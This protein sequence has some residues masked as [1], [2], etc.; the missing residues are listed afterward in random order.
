MMQNSQDKDNISSL[1]GIP[2]NHRDA[3]NSSM[4]S[5]LKWQREPTAIATPSN[6]ARLN[7]DMI[8][9]PYGASRTRD[10]LHADRTSF[11]N[12][13][14]RSTVT[15][16]INLSSKKRKWD[17]TF[18]ENNNG[19]GKRKSQPKQL[20]ND[21]PPLA[22]DQEIILVQSDN[23]EDLGLPIT[24]DE[25]NIRP[26][27]PSSVKNDRARRNSPL[28]P[29]EMSD[30]QPPTSYSRTRGPTDGNNTRWL[31]E[32]L[33]RPTSPIEDYDDEFERD[34]GKVKGMVADYERRRQ[35]GVDEL[36][37]KRAAPPKIPF[38]DLK[39]GKEAPKA[40]PNTV[41]IK[42]RMKPKDSAKGIQLLPQ[43]QRDRSAASTSSKTPTTSQFTLPVKEWYLGHNHFREP[44]TL[45]F[46]KKDSQFTIGKHGHSEV[47]RLARDVDESTCSLDHA[48]VQIVTK[49]DH[50]GVSAIGPDH[51]PSFEP[52]HRTRGLILFSFDEGAA[53][54]ST[55]A[56]TH[57]CECLRGRNQSVATGIGFWKMHVLRQQ[58]PSRSRSVSVVAESDPE[59][60]KRDSESVNSTLKPR[61][62]V[63]YRAS[64]KQDLGANQV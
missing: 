48:C 25:L 8:N 51:R 6:S 7:R 60:P 32:E 21:V 39:T 59:E 44:Y 29:F 55:D 30:E 31:Q 37:R 58:M 10:T 45:T 3:S 13:T 24:S 34:G 17:Q 62:T 64:A 41:S 15:R 56:Y 46:K 22:P 9:G 40:T 35:K 63:T 14:S 38:I 33:G 4:G 5:N 53:T 47:I 57:F 50:E 11:G 19:H 23:E 49:P 61:T 16:A 43:S 52:G 42:N 1:H 18:T 54:W 12:Q 36:I 27:G 28:H 2:R 20:R 26:A